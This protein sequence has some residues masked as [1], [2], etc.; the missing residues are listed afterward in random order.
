MEFDS[1]KMRHAYYE[2]LEKINNG[3]YRTSKS[4]REVKLQVLGNIGREHHQTSRDKTSIAPAV[5]LVCICSADQGHRNSCHVC[6]ERLL[7][8]RKPSPNAHWRC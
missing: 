6:K 4:W 7:G 2:K 5:L 1:K 8:R 3:R